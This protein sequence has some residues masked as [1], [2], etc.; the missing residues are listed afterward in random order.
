MYKQ[1]VKVACVIGLW[2]VTGSAMANWQTG[3]DILAIKSDN[4]KRVNAFAGVVGY[5]FNVSEKFAIVPEFTLGAGIKK[6][7]E[8]GSEQTL[9][10]SRYMAGS[11]NAR[12]KVSPKMYIFGGPTVDK[13][14]YRV[15]HKT[16]GKHREGKWRAGLKAGFGYQI[17]SAI[18]AEL[19]YGQTKNDKLFRAGIRVKF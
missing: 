6:R 9:K 1:L 8:K 14:R 15:K 18:A 4:H 19:S 7:R 16:N 10:L 11:L 3:A 12:Y 17:S 5:Q 13:V 2:L